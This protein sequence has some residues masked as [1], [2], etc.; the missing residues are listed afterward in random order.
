MKFKCRLC[1]SKSFNKIIDLGN[2]PLSGTFPKITE[3][4]PI[5]SPLELIRC[6]KCDL[7][8]LLAS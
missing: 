3:K 6:K 2:Q 8:Q 4:D 1:N 5:K 7:I